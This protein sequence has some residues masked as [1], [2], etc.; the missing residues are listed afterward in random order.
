MTMNEEE[1]KLLEKA[2]A[3][4][5][6]AKRSEAEADDYRK[7]LS[8]PAYTAWC[9]A[10]HP[11]QGRLRNEMRQHDSKGARLRTR[12]FWFMNEY[13]INMNRLIDSLAKE[14]DEGDLPPVSDAPLR[15][16]DGSG[17][18]RD[19]AGNYLAPAWRVGECGEGA[20]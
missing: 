3:A 8:L 14:V 10:G 15:N 13:A 9:R 4:W 19:E 7:R 2:V 20:P 6:L 17:R 18:E 12:S 16:P 11:V 1:L 5:K